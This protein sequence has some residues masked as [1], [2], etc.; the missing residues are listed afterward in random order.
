MNNDRFY[1]MQTEQLQ[2]LHLEANLPLENK[3][4]RLDQALAS[5]FP[6]HSRSRLKEWVEKGWV[7]VDGQK[8]RA[9]DKVQGGEKIIIQAEIPI[10]LERG[11]EAIPLDIIYEDE[12]VLVLN[13]PVGL[14]VH[15]AVGNQTGTLLNALLHHYPDLNQIPRAGIVHRLD[16]D[17][18]GLMIVAKSLEAHTHLVNQLQARTVRRTYETIVWGI[19]PAG[20]TVNAR[21]GRHPVDRKRMSVSDTGKEAITHYRVVQKFRCHTH[22][23][24]QLE[25]GRTHQIRVHMAYIHHPIL[26]DKT[27]GGRLR[28]PPKSTPEFLK[29]LR[30]FPRQALHATQLGFIHPITDEEMHWEIP[31]PKDILQL[32]T[33]LKQN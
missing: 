19:L 26:G 33:A 2:Q 15:P 18:S 29:I 7:L 13:K 16:K 5:L 11:A 22:L 23:R 28:V 3:G 25:T 1:F 32:L 14:V 8:K 27:Y 12:H 20:G 9:K 21:I 4:A 6:E 17:T 30:E 24:V 31:L 10:I